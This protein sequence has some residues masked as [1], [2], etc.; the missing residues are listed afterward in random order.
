[1]YGAA[2]NPWLFQV[3]SAGETTVVGFGGRDVPSDFWIGRY[4]DELVKIVRE[5]NCREL[6][7]DLSGV[8]TIPSGALGLLSSLSDLGVTISIFNPSDDVREILRMTN[9]C[10]L[11][12]IR[13]VDLDE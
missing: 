10:E 1:M 5:Q 6:A 7:F 12:E 2:D 13:E 8:V 11:I 9:L 4:K 3:Y